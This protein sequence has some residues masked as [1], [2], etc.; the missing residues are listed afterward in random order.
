MSRYREIPLPPH[1]ADILSAWNELAGKST[2]GG[3]LDDRENGLAA[4]RRRT[5]EVREAL[6]ADRL[7]VFDVAEGWQPL[8]EF[9]EVD[10]PDEPFP[11]HNLRADFWEVLGG[12]PS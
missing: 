7:L 3:V 2:F 5:E 10:V 1:I 9:L 11:H 6:P 4:Y 12:E 8:C